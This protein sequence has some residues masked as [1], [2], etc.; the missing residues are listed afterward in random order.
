MEPDPEF[1]STPAAKSIEMRRWAHGRAA[2]NFV[3]DCI[4]ELW[5]SMAPQATFHRR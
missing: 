4:R 2:M 3:P 5:D 1:L